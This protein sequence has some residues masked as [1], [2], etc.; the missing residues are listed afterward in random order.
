MTELP[1]LLT[2][3]GVRAVVIG[4]TQTPNCV[5]ATA[6]DAISHD[7]DTTVLTDGTSAATPEIHQANLRDMSN[8]GIKLKSC[9]EVVRELARMKG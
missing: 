3:L 1:L 4:G 8:I 2:R 6:F 9:D 5:R 7:L